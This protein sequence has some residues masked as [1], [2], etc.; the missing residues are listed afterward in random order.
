MKNKIRPILLASRSPRRRKILEFLGIPFKVVL[1]HGVIERARP[2][3]LPQRLVKRLAVEKAR[4]VARKYPNADVLAADTV[5][6]LA[7]KI[8][9][10]PRGRKEA[11]ATLMKL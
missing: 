4:S 11:L 6:S 10:K 1:P 3:E 9:G 5:V 7:G 2:N 8:Y